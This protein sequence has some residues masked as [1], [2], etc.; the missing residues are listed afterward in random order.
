MRACA[1]PCAEAAPCCWHREPNASSDVKVGLELLR[2]G[3]RG[4]QMNV[5]I[6]LGSLKDGAAYA[7]PWTRP[8]RTSGGLSRIWLGQAA[9]AR[10]REEAV[11]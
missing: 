8:P 7:A 10:L 6:N 9:P 11:P 1:R 2:A 5:E 4:A 3:L